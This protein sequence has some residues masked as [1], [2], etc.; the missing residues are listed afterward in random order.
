V[1]ASTFPEAF[2]IV[3]AEVMASG[4]ALVTS[5]VGGAAELIE[6]GVSGLRFAP[7]DAASLAAALQQLLA[8]PDLLWR[9][10]QAGQQRVRVRFSVTAAAEQLE[11]LF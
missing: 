6:P 5:G 11:R 8:D 1:F 9:L 7:G 10:A 2:G 4:V 3:A